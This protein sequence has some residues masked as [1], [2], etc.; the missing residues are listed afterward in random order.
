MANEEYVALLKR[1][2]DGW[3]EWRRGNPNI[4]PNLHGTRL[5]EV[6]LPPSFLSEKD[7][8]SVMGYPFPLEKREGKADLRRAHLP[9]V[10]FSNMCLRESTLS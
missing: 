3:N 7:P 1:G 8:C 2:V 9:N 10:D 4:L 5:P 6:H